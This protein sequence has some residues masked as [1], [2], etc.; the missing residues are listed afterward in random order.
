MHHWTS[1]KALIPVCWRIFNFAAQV[2][3]FDHDVSGYDLSIALGVVEFVAW[4]FRA[5]IRWYK[6]NKPRS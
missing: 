5:I 4:A 2:L 6:K 3:P 1:F